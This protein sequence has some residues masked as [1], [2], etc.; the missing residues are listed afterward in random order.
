MDTMS[1]I[2]FKK[3]INSLVYKSFKCL[4]YKDPEKALSRGLKPL[5]SDSDILQLAE[6]VSGFNVVDVY[7]DQGVIETLSKKLND[8]EDDDVVVIDGVEA[9]VEAMVEGEVEA[10]GVG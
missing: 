2:D 5:N 1:Y 3:L 6:D 7:V 9:Q 8:V 10:E 4:W